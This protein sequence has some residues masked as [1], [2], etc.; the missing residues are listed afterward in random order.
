MATSF[1]HL[2]KLVND[3]GKLV[4]RTGMYPFL[5]A[6]FA[7]IPASARVLSIGA[8]G[9][10]NR[11]LADVQRKVGFT[12]TQVDIDPDRRP[13]VVA[14]IC[15]W[16]SEQP[17]DVILA[18]EVLEHLT[19]PQRALANMRAMLAPG[20]RLIVTVP[21]IFPIHDA[22]HDYFRYTRHGLE[23]LLRDFSDVKIEERTSW[24]EAFGVLAVR[25]V[26]GRRR[27]ALAAVVVPAVLAGYPLLRAA[28]RLLPSDV[29]PS[30]YNIVA[31][32]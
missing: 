23:M 30:G 15:T 26:R 18:A 28:G 16:R 10:I 31:R 24:A 4:S 3:G 27:R 9:E 12:L 14:D 17:F 1:R 6:E 13:D 32:G 22:P 5:D 29:M 7:Q 19:E 25:L 2:T 8:G 20:G 11:R 21:F